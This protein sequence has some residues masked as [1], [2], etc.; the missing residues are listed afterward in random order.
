VFFQSPVALTPRALNDAPTAAGALAQNVYEWHEG[1]VYLISD[2]KD[3]AQTLG[4]SAVTLLGSDAS[5]ANVFFSTADRLVFQDTDTGIDFYDARI[6]TAG[7]PCVAAPAPVAAA[8]GGEACRGAAG[9][10]PVFGAP[11]SAVFSGAGNLAPAQATPVAAPK[12]KSKPKKKKARKP[13][14]K[15]RGRKAAQTG[16]QTK[17][18]RR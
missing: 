6:C 4:V 9:A 12:K 7:E 18:G 13:R 17:R 11:G 16:K 8:C 5:G 10:S 2:G 3:T 15:R 1:H 14:R